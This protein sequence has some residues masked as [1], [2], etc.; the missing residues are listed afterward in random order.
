MKQ[1]RRTFVTAS[2]GAAAGLK[3]ASAQAPSI[4]AK[5]I[6]ERIQRNL[7]VPWRGGPP[8]HSKPATRIRP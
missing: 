3:V 6:V 4:T 7:G 1:S 5:Q 8:I 2:L